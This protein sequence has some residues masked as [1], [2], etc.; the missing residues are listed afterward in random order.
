MALS[1]QQKRYLR[2]LTHSAQ[3]VVTIAD[4]GLSDTVVA[5][6]EGALRHH[7]LIKIK[8]RAERGVRK[9]W[10]DEITKLCKAEQVH[11]IG[12]VVCFYRRN[13][14]NPVIALPAEK[15]PKPA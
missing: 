9:H 15:A 11:V 5:E 10:V 7:E 12:Q 2:G 6:I 4:K 14:K 3:P 1:S 8:M 13:P